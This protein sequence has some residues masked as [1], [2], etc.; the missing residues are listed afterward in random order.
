MNPL[1]YLLYPLIILI[2]FLIS[3]GASLLGVGGGILFVPLLE[4]YTGDI[5]LATAI[6]TF[7]IV[8]LSLSATTSFSLQRRIDLKTSLR[9]APFVICGGIIG[10]FF[11]D[12]FPQALLR[13]FFGVAL[14]SISLFTLFRTL[15]EKPLSNAN[16]STTHF[17]PSEKIESSGIR[18]LLSSYFKYKVLI[19]EYKDSPSV[20]YYVDLRK[21]TPF[22]FLGGLMAGILGLGGGVIYVPL[23]VSVLGIPIHIAIATSAF[24]IFLGS[25]FT[26]I[27]RFPSVI[28]D[29]G[30]TLPLTL[31]A[32]I[33]ARVGAIFL[34]KINSKWLTILFWCVTLIVGIRYILLSTFQILL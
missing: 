20:L 27:V 3:L 12:K 33:G 29:W 10:G 30:I 32:V 7:A 5:H 31:G 22:A 23:L 26:L 15:K 11:A 6:S 25:T 28:W 13:G 4:I 18:N 1:S 2:G 24:L 34:R 16:S 9:L 14:I 8:F 17:S 21:G 19:P